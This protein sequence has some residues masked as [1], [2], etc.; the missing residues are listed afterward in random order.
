MALALLASVGC[1]PERVEYHYRPAYVAE[2]EG[3]PLEETFYRPDGT[4]VVITA[5]VPGLDPSL[6]APRTPQAVTPDGTAP[7]PKAESPAGRQP[8]QVHTADMVLEAFMNGLRDETYAELY[9]RLVSPQQRQRM[10]GE[11]GRAV[12]VKFC[13]DNRREL[14]ASAL[15]M[16]STV[17]SGESPPI[18]V[19]GEIT[20][21]QMPERDRGQFGFTVLEVERRPDGGLGLAGI[22]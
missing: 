14:M 22:R 7:P 11:S 8:F 13:E 21:F 1:A 19:S 12:F 18:A 16:V 17:R 20:R 3:R 4:K 6:A 9:D 2:N 15:R 5:N 10:G